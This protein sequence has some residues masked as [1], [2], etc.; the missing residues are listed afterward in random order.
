MR[1]NTGFS[2]S[3]DSLAERES[4]KMDQSSK[5]EQRSTITKIESTSI[6]VCLNKEN[7]VNRVFDVN[8]FTFIPIIGDFVLI[9][10]IKRKWKVIVEIQPW[11]P[12]KYRGKVRKINEEKGYGIIDRS[13]VFDVKTTLSQK[14]LRVGDIVKGV[15]LKGKWFLLNSNCLNFFFF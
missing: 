8:F 2:V 12:T 4:Y 7:E 1:K 10:T 3:D 15:L 5:F 9:T 13:V 6:F 14:Q 11:E